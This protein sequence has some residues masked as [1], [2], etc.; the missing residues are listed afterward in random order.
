M[1]TLW[2]EDDVTAGLS[3]WESFKNY[4]PL[5]TCEERKAGDPTSTLC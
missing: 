4:R 2:S 5:E 3:V 1:Q